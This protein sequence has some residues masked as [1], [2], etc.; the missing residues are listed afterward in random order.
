M[1]DVSPPVPL[2]P[3]PA[4]SGNEFRDRMRLVAEAMEARFPPH[5]HAGRTIPMPEEGGLDV[6]GGGASSACSGGS[7]GGGLG[8]DCRVPSPWLAG[9]PESRGLLGSPRQPVGPAGRRAPTRRG[10]RRDGKEGGGQGEGGE[11][12]GQGEGGEGG[13]QGEAISHSEELPP[14][15]P[16]RVRAS[17]PF[18]AELAAV[19]AHR[20]IQMEIVEA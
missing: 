16:R 13:G 19:M 1:P 17:N 18:M 15:P 2:L 12:G 5:Q 14:P 9:R 20:E 10:G 11:G 4:M 3:P 7:G 8:R 6:P